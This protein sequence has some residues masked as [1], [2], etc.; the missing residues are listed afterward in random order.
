MLRI[1][2]YIGSFAIIAV[3]C[4]ALFG[5]RWVG[6]LLEA[7]KARELATLDA[8]NERLCRVVDGLLARADQI[9]QHQK[10]LPQSVDL[11]SSRR[12]GKTCSELVTLAESL[13][14][15]KAQLKSR[16]LRG[17]RDSLVKCCR[18]ATHASKELD[19]VEMS[20]L[21]VDHEP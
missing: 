10:Y 9:D 17:S 11:E 1:F 13:T 15:V 6:K 8:Y 19:L 14:L 2:F 3:V 18:V 7:R 21:I 12:L 20:A 5:W 4:F 16:D